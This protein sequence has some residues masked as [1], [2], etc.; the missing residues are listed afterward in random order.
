VTLAEARRTLN[1]RDEEL[2]LL[3]RAGRLRL[4]PVTADGPSVTDSSVAEVQDFLRESRNS[5]AVYIRR[6][7]AVSR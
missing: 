2:R 1:L 5:L 4:G 3:I 7:A 6:R